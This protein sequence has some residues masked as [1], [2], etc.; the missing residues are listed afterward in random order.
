[1][2]GLIGVKFAGGTGGTGGTGGAFGAF[3]IGGITNV[4]LRIYFLE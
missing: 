3:G 4:F 2:G 1:M